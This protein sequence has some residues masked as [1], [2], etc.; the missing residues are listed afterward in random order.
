MKSPSNGWWKWFNSSN[1]IPAS[2]EES[3]QHPSAQRIDKKQACDL[4]TERS[5]SSIPRGTSEET[6]TCPAHQSTN[7][8]QHWVY[9]SEQ[10]FYNAMLRKGHS[11][12]SKDVPT[13]LSIHNA[14]NEK[15]WQ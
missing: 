13:I 10:Q 9:P 5:T 2:I 6:S 14:V 11:P 1:N 3:L 15:T 4:R 7:S 12:S 8:S